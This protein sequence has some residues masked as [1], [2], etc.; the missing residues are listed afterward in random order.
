MR[1]LL[2]ALRNAGRLIIVG[3]LVFA[4][5]NIGQT[6]AQQSAS[7]NPL[8]A[9]QIEQLV[10]PIALYPDELLSQVL[11]A[12]TYPLE[13]VAA[14]RWSQAN[15]TVTGEALKTA[16]ANQPWDPSV[17][18]LTALP[19]TL[20][21]M[22]DKL[23]WTQQLGDAFLAQQQDVLDAVQ[24]LRA[25]ADAN[26]QLKSSPEQTV[27]IKP[28]GGSQPA[29]TAVPSNVYMIE[30]TNP[31]EYYVPIY[32]PGVVYGAW[33]Y[34]DYQPFYWYPP[35]Y[36]YGN[37]FSFAAGVVVGSA[38]WGNVDWLGNR[39][40]VNPLRYN[41]FNRTNIT[42][43]NWAHNPAHRGAVPYRDAGVAQRF[44]D[45]SRQG[46]RENFRSQADAGRRDLGNQSP[47]SNLGQ[48]KGG[49]LGQQKA[50]NLGQ[51]K[52]QA[53]Q[54]AANRTAG[55]DRTAGGSN[56]AAGKNAAANKSKT[57]SKAAANKNK[58]TSKTAANKNK[59]TSK[60][61]ANNRPAGNREAQRPAASRQAARPSPGP[62]RSAGARS[63]GV[64][65]GARAAGGPGGGGRAGGGRGG[66]GRRSDV[67]LKHDITL[68]GYLDNG[69]GFYRFSYNGSSEPYVGVLA[70]DVQQV[71]PQAVVRDREGYLR[72]FYD[73][74]GLRFQTYR[75]WIAAGAHVP[76]GGGDEH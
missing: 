49:N 4:V 27:T 56:K 12:S 74:L 17:K 45:Q 10:A 57:S 3:I 15:P 26:G 29:T 69:I 1:Q 22:N 46:A 66:G 62:S 23:D 25:R 9:A 30:P 70:Q 37:A 14:T 67:R 41:N 75:E 48:Q 51:Q 39:V 24:R 38:I 16:M 7:T 34:S 68:L 8:G 65:G 54:K 21:M 28:R 19:Q 58:G 73:R 32:D 64:G 76:T 52:G 53:G 50:G 61:A 60:T 59:G 40:Q 44:G 36:A 71:M 72:V 31:D 6:R 47:A 20:Q 43:A 2:H 55:A 33:P 5:L 13:V 42:N 35:G 63:V 11:M 18:A